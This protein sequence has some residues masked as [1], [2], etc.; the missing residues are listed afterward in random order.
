MLGAHT[1]MVFTKKLAAGLKEWSDET[2][3]PLDNDALRRI[4]WKYYLKEKERVVTNTDWL[5]PEC[6]Y[7]LF[8]IY[9]RL[10][11]KDDTTDLEVGQV[12]VYIP[13]F[14]ICYPVKTSV[15]YGNCPDWSLNHPIHV[16]T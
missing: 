3:V 15:L 13:C 16:C 4:C 11:L 10:L 9:N 14:Y 1:P 2:D 12:S 7:R 8:L 5:S 6:N